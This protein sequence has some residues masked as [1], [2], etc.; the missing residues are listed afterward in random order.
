MR[1]E[2]IE[3]IK[4]LKEHL[5]LLRYSGITDVLYI[6]EEFCSAC[7]RHISGAA[8]GHG[9][10]D[11]EVFFVLGCPPKGQIEGQTG[12]FDGETGS[13]LQK[14]IQWMAR[15]SKNERFKSAGDAYV[16]YAVKCPDAASCIDEAALACKP[17]LEKELG[18]VKPK[19]VVALGGAA[20]LAL[21]GSRDV[22]G[23]RGRAHVLGGAKLIISHAVA[24]IIRNAELK[25]E[26][27]ADLE[28]ALE[29]ISKAAV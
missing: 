6:K 27:W 7:A 15:V 25:K 24:D 20:A 8:Q 14:I 3:I 5:E 26:A 18:A 23:L 28:L 10:A 2:L 4:C 13:Q 12:H 17:L 11:A 9:R 21:T 22:K 19:V 29:E 1:E 16:S